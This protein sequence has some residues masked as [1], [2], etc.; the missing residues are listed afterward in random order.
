VSIEPLPACFIAIIVGFQAGHKHQQDDA[1][2]GEELKDLIR[3]QPAQQ[4]GTDQQAEQQL[5]KHSQQPEALAELRG[6][7]GTNQNAGE[8]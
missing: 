6:S 8:R 3:F 4:C 1:D 5:A 7:H 2:I